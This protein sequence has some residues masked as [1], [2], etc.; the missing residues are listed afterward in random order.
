MG[1]HNLRIITF[2]P[3]KG[4]GEQKSTGIIGKT[5]ADVKLEFPSLRGGKILRR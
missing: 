2:P 4:I 5:G 3:S 1:F